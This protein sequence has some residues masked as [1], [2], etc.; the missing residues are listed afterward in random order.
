MLTMQSLLLDMVLKMELTIGLSRIH[1]AKSGVR[2]ATS[3]SA[4]LLIAPLGQMECAMSRH[5][6]NY[7]K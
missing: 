2:T 1:G 4:S 7:L 5:L 3:D 6:Y